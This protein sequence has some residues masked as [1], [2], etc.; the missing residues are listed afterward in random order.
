MSEAGQLEMETIVIVS[1]TMMMLAT[2]L[3]TLYRINRTGKRKNSQGKR[4]SQGL[5]GVASKIHQN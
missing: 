2:F 3:A 1:N 4:E 5:P